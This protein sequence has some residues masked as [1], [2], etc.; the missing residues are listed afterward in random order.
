M[1]LVKE[2]TRA[3]VQGLNR[4]QNLQFR[5][6]RG[7]PFHQKCLG[8]DAMGPFPMSIP[9]SSSYIQPSGRG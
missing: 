9:I 7:V 6:W 8:M 1:Q 2:V 5:A 4:Q 3:A